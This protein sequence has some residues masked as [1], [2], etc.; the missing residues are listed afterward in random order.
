MVKCTCNRPETWPT[1][2]S[3]AT[4]LDYFNQFT[5]FDARVAR[6]NTDAAIWREQNIAKVTLTIVKQLEDCAAKLRMPI[7]ITHGVQPNQ[8]DIQI[9]AQSGVRLLGLLIYA[10]GTVDMLSSA[11]ARIG[12]WEDVTPSKLGDVLSALGRFLVDHHKRY[13]NLVEKPSEPDPQTSPA[14]TDAAPEHPD[15]YPE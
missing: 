4:I 5:E 3:P 6:D 13:P 12:R 10:G 2:S 7:A 11:S 8:G 1:N 15:H 9:Y 14:P